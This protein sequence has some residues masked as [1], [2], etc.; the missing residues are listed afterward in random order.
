MYIKPRFGMMK[1]LVLDQI[2]KELGQLMDS[3]ARNRLVTLLSSK[4]LSYLIKLLQ[5]PSEEIIH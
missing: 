4:K 5:T 2:L 3:G 1:T